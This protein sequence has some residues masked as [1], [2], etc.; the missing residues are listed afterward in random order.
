MATAAMPG[1]QW[2]VPRPST[3]WHASVE[4]NVSILPTLSLLVRISL[5]E[6][7]LSTR[8]AKGS[9]CCAEQSE[10]VGSRPSLQMLHVWLPVGYADNEAVRYPCDAGVPV[11]SLWRDCAGLQHMRQALCNLVNNINVA[12]FLEL[13]A[14]AFP[15]YAYIRWDVDTIRKE[16]RAAAARLGANTLEDIARAFTSLLSASLRPRIRAGRFGRCP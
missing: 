14:L 13:Q 2:L 7:S 15:L 4:P 1:H 12:V 5:R 16:E 9:R 3:V 8:I 11:C 6:V 10:G